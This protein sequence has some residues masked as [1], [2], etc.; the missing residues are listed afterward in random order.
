M[1]CNN[2]LSTNTVAVAVTTALAVSTMLNGNEYIL[3]SQN[4]DVTQYR[5]N[6]L[7]SES[8]NLTNLNDSSFTCL[9]ISETIN[10][11]LKELVS[12]IKDLDDIVIDVVNENFWDL[13]GE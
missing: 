1:V 13:V 9:S 10:N 5:N 4:Y 11:F 2:T 12:G 8:F 6:V 3:P 7:I